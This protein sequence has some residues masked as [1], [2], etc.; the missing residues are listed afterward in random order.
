MN[1][2]Q[3]NFFALIILAAVT[4]FSGIAVAE[5]ASKKQKQ[6]AELNM[7]IVD[8]QQAGS[9]ITTVS[10]EAESKA[11]GFGLSA[12]LE[13]SQ[14][15]AVDERTPRTNDLSVTI[16]P[17]YNFNKTF[18]LS[19]KTIIIKENTGAKATKASDTKVILSITGASLTDS[20][21]TTHALIGSLPTSETS[22]KRD[23][24]KG[25]VAVAS[26]L[27]LTTKY[28]AV[29]YQLTLSRNFHEYTFNAEGTSN[30]EYR[31]GHSLEVK[32]PVTEKLYL[33]SLNI[34][35]VGTTYGG[36]Q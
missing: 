26:G 7:S 1:F 6:V 12:G 4:G 19:T 35:R 21:K 25:A 14:N 32:L 20:L 28:I 10:N 31:T 29:A 5:G 15:I 36:T 11:L 16:I 22:Q 8:Q 13:Y 17:S 24:L 34:Y 18:A 9:S 2:I 33:T 23:R 30:V 3:K 27:T